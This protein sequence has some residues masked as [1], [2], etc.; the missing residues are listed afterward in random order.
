[1]GASPEALVTKMYD[2]AIQACYQK[3]EKRLIDILSALT[4]SLNLDY[5]LAS[6]L[7]QLYKYC[8]QQAREHNFEEV[9]ELLKGVRDIWKE[10]VEPEASQT[11]PKSLKRGFVG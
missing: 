5:E 4:T 8:Q 6:S 9:I 2:F 10:H 1:M 11:K 3:D 7:Y